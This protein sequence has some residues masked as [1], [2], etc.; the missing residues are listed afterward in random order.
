MG[1]CNVTHYLYLKAFEKT[2]TTHEMGRYGVF[3]LTDQRTQLL[4]STNVMNYSSLTGLS[5]ETAIRIDHTFHLS[6][7]GGLSSKMRRKSGSSSSASNVSI[8]QINCKY[9]RSM[10]ETRLWHKAYSIIHILAGSRLIFDNG[11]VFD[12]MTVPGRKRREI[13]KIL[14]EKSFFV[15]DIMSTRKRRIEEEPESAKR[16]KKDLSPTDSSQSSVDE[17]SNDSYVSPPKRR[18]P[19]FEA[20][21]PSPRRSKTSTPASSKKRSVH[22][23]VLLSAGLAVELFPTE[24]KDVTFDEE[25]EEEPKPIKIVDEWTKDFPTDLSMKTSVKFFSSKPFDVSW[26]YHP[27]SNHEQACP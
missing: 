7:K 10:S 6:F 21:T 5:S 25:V 4:L 19:K 22:R 13:Q 8:L 11:I 3:K 2:I 26:H 14:E 18:R 12:E 9:S 27:S 16:V 17:S 1:S 20:F 23:S 15:S 24:N